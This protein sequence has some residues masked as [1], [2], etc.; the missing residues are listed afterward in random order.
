MLKTI[1]ILYCN[2]MCY[3]ILTVKKSSKQIPKF[4]TQFSIAKTVLYITPFLNNVYF[5]LEHTHIF[6]T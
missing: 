1:L 3:T 4:Y 6:Y 2:G 5:Y